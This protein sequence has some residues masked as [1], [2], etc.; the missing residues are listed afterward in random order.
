MTMERVHGVLDAAALAC[1][2]AGVGVIVVAVAL[3]ALRAVWSGHAFRLRDHR[4]YERFKEPFARALLL[5]MDLLVAGDIVKSVALELH[6]PDLKALALL[7]AVR[8]FLAWSLLTEL[9]GR[10]PWRAGE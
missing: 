7:V 6:W 8:T 1:E 10:P 5:G 9:E 4:S 2:L 3:A